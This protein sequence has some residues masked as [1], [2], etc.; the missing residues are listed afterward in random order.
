MVKDKYK[1]KSLPMQIFHT[2]TGYIVVIVVLLTIAS[3]FYL[4]SESLP[5]FESWSC[6]QIRDF[7]LNDNQYGNP[8]NKKHMDLTEAEH[9]RLH[10]IYAECNLTDL[11]EK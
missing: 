9:N 8:D 10:Q 3:G 4:Y 5:F 1:D 6:G 2:Y 7:L 11:H